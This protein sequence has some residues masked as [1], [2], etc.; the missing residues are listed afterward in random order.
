M[1]FDIMEFGGFYP[2][3]AVNLPALFNVVKLNKELG[4]M[5]FEFATASRI[6]FGN[7]QR[8]ELASASAELGT[9]P[10]IV[11]GKNR[12]RA[13]ALVGAIQESGMRCIQFTVPG[14]PT[15][16]LMS[17]GVA[18]ARQNRCDLFIGIGGGSV[19]DTTK[20][21]AALLNN[22]EPVIAY[23]EVIGEGKPLLKPAAPSIAVPTT[24]GTGAEVTANA[25]L[26]SRKQRV[27]VSLR[28]QSMLPDLA[29]VDP[30]LTYGMPPA[31][32]AATG[33]D[34][35][36]QL[37]EAFV[38]KFSNPMTDLFCREGMT[39]VARSLARAVADGFDPTARADMALASLF[40]GMALANSKLGAVHG[41]AGPMG[42]LIE[43]PHGVICARLLPFVMAQNIRVL[44]REAHQA[45]LDRYD[46]VA[47]VLTGNADAAALDGVAWVRNLLPALDFPKL[48]DFGLKP[49]MFTQIVAMAQRAS[50]MGG[51]PV[52]LSEDELFQVLK[53]AL[54][55]END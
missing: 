16:S 8:H 14:E 25:V 52:V 48:S 4:H 2:R 15:V 29:I 44:L 23:L 30:E 17:E 3:Y 13:A 1:V 26:G 12:E 54:G 5:K 37:L 40:S 42:G 55:V 34:A 24:A 28:H 20:A 39:R 33:L 49:E 45:Q 36:T 22:T 27:K 41:F 9:L 38:S 7:G 19:I 47:R 43:A 11:T 50:S 6:L 21:L 31:L 10:M 53:N 18:L 51:N 35:L 46:Q 32:T